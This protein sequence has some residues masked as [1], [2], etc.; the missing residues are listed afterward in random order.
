MVS[1]VGADNLFSVR[2]WDLPTRLCHGALALLF[3]ALVLSGQIGGDLMVWHMRCG[4]AMLSLVIWRIVWGF[5]GGY[6]SRFSSFVST[7]LQAWRFSRLPLD[8]KQGAVGHNPL[9]AWSVVAMLCL[10]GLQAW[11]GLFSDDQIATSGPLTALVSEAWVERATQWHTGPGKWALIALVVL[12]LGSIY[13]Y[14]KVGRIDLLRPML[15]GDKILANPA[16]DSK[17][18]TA[19]RWLAAMLLLLCATA[20]ALL[21]TSGPL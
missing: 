5:I 8:E 4:Y 14:R 16:P 17:D 12:H 13:W 1:F 21:V 7:P 11:A 18:S 15:T 2:V 10:L 19:S 9:G 6:W 3:F 20:V